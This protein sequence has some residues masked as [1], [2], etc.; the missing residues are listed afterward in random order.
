MSNVKKT[1]ARMIIW[2]TLIA[3]TVVLIAIFAFMN[4][5]RFGRMPQGERLERI[6]RSPN[7]RNGSFHNQ[8]D[9]PVITSDKSRISNLLEFAFRKTEG[10]R[11]D[12]AVSVIKTDLKK[13]SRDRNMLVWFGH[14]SY[15]IQIDGKRILV[16]PVFRTAAPVSFLN[17]PFK[18]TDT[19]TPEDMPDIDYLIISHDHWDHLDYET[20]TEMRGRIGKAVCALGVG[21]HLEYWGFDKEQIIELD[22]LEDANADTGFTFYCLPAR[23][24]SGRGLNPNQTLWASFLLQT[25]S[26]KIYIGGDGGYDTH[27][28]VI[29]ERFDG[30]DLAILENGQY[31]KDWR[32]IH[33]M[34]EYMAKAAKDLKAK[35][36]LTVH[37]SKYA[38]AKHPW[39]E[40][41]QNAHYM[42]EHDSLNVLIPEIGEIVNLDL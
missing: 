32:Y 35:K 41:L 5:P 2:Y 16:D 18:G 27:F 33:L 7:Y 30:V 9:A 26:A 38:L 20:I 4:H 24:F 6:R 23:H 34:P 25:S 36:V 28:A 42:A 29:G 21:E 10:L 1:K 22:W 13:I 15:F 3:V 14:S 31:N 11:P 12:S 37:H 8:H 17:K 39:D 19:Y 40:P